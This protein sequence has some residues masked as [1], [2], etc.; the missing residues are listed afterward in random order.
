MKLRTRQFI[1][2]IIGVW[3]IYISGALSYWIDMEYNFPWWDIFVWLPITS[4]GIFFI[5]WFTRIEVRTSKPAR[6]GDKNG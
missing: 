5:L 6:P 4:V 2:M 1:R 3:L